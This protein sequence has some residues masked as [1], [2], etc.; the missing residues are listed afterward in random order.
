MAGGRLP[1]KGAPDAVLPLCHAVP[2]VDEALARM[3][4][5]GL[6]VLAV[7]RGDTAEERDLEFLGL[8]GLHDPPR[9]DVAEAIWKCRIAGIKLAMVTGDHPRTARAIAAEVGLLGEEE[10]VVTGAD[11]PTDDAALGELL[12]RDGVVVARVAPEDKL[13]IARAL[14]SRGHVVAMT[15]RRCSATTRS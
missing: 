3:S 1:L 2:G 14:R 6:R 5:R 9:D 8:V 10:L 4:D 15:G 12:D 7:A 11:L 13:R